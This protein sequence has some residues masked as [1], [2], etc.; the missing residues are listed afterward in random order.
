[1]DIHISRY[2][3]PM[4]LMHAPEPR[5]AY[6]IDHTGKRRGKMTAI[7]WYHPS[8][9]GKGAL[10]LCRCECGLFEY[11]RPGNWG[12]KPHPEDMCDTCL[13]AKGPN[14]RQTAQA[15]LQRWTESLR[16]LGLTDTE[17]ALIQTLGID[18]EIQGKTA[19]EVRE[20]IAK[21]MPM[22]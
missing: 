16:N 20:Q 8:H 13:R 21:G 10:W 5:P 19:A 15:R 9:S 11:R 18:I 4:H 17:I 12:T 14:A 7:A 3:D 2:H 6:A 1:M 22:N